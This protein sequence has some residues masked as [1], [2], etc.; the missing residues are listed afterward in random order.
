MTIT[1]YKVLDRENPD[2]SRL[3]LEENDAVCEVTWLKGLFSE[4]WCA[5]YY[6]TTEIEK[7]GGQEV[8]IDGAVAT[9]SPER[10]PA[11]APSPPLSATCAAQMRGFWARLPLW[12]AR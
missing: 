3:F 10:M 4:Q 9:S 2:Y 6:V 12:G 7:I 5:P 1:A 11:T 8:R